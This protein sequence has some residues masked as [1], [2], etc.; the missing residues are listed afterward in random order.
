FSL[1]L[2]IILLSPILLRKLKIPGIIGL[3]ISGVI[4]GPHCLNILEKTSAIDLF[5]TI[6]L[7]YIMFIAG[8]ELDM[9]EF[10]QNKFKSLGF[11]VF[12]FTIPIL[13]GVPTCYYLLDYD[14][15]ASIL[16]ASM[17][18]THTL[19]AYPIVSKFGI[20]KNEAV[21][22]T[23]G[24]TIFTDTAVLI[25]FAIIL[26]TNQGNLTPEFWLRFGVSLIVFILIMFLIIPRIA[27]WFF[28]RL[29]A[30]KT[31]HYIF[32]LSI[33]F[34]AAFLAQEAGVEPIIGA[35]VSGLALNRLI[36]HSSVLMNRLQFVGNAIF[37]PFFL[38]SVGMVVDISVLL[39]GPMAWI[40]AFTLSFFALL[41]KYGAAFITKLLFKYSKL[42]GQ[43]IFGLS[44]S[45]AAATLA[46]ILIGYK[47]GI[48]DEN[49]LNGTIILILI[50]CI[51]ASF[52]TENAAKKILSSGEASD[53]K[54]DI[55]TKQHENILIPI[56]NFNNLESLIDFTILIKDKK[57]PYPV[58]L[59]SVVTDD[60]EAEINF[61]KVKKTL[62]DSIR[63]ISS[64]D[65]L[66]K[67]LVTIDINIANGIIRTSR[68]IFADTIIMGW[69]E[70]ES[71]MDKIFGHKIINIIET[72]EKNIIL[73]TLKKPVN[74]CRKIKL[75]C[76]PSI[77][78]E[79]GFHYW[80]NKIF[81]LAGELST[82]IEFY[83]SSATRHETVEFLKN[84]RHKV[85]V[86]FQ[87]FAFPENLR[88]FSDNISR[89][90]L[91]IIVSPR[92]GAV[93]YTNDFEQIPKRLDKYFKKNSIIIIYPMINEIISRYEKYHDIDS[94][95]L[96]KGMDTVSKI[97]KGIGSIFGKR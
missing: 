24:G 10:R 46:I 4:I 69:P 87:E 61:I 5:S 89:D 6:G 29:E 78:L 70:K 81:Y 9:N 58:N 92:K 90:D 28:I 1:I 3:I 47:A 14:I 17:F 95:L 32:V 42:Q 43:L 40:I 30:E 64:T 51:V 41:G 62:D 56:A 79:K 20:S 85:T 71:L 54:T 55:L 84:T 26:G 93:S 8:L 52:V 86:L 60:N 13:L 82:G 37:I 74:T 35:F 57:S 49:I 80:L 77:E 97:Q 2:F 12:T 96:T 7:L 53:I 11:G 27:R 73:C 65:I 21:A 50:T 72:V 68:E 88:K 18:A 75:I 66:L 94:E 45:H 38:I 19:V 83:C 63:N 16:T 67:P 33:V 15:N 23:V 48:I 44:S 39:N 34:F 25:L 91:L 59:L 22:I 31:S 76:P 36:P